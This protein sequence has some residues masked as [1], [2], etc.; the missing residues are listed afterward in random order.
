MNAVRFDETGAETGRVD[1][2][3]ALF[4]AEPNMDVLH[5][6][7]VTYLANQRQG[8][9]AAKTRADVS[10]TNRKPFKQKKTGQARRGDM[11]TN[12]QRGG[13]VYGGP[14]PRDYRQKM[15]KKIKQLALR[16]AL[17][18]RA[19]EEAVS[20]VVDLS[21][22]SG[23]TRD[24][25]SLLK[26]AGMQDKRVLFVADKP[27]ATLQRASRNIEKL[28]LTSVGSL[29]TYA[30]MW[31]ERV[32]FTESALARLSEVSLGVAR[33]NEAGGAQ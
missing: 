28:W 7:V 18:I 31:A 24:V 11:K 14:I 33:S 21:L 27:S 16:S 32:V 23:K 6:A 4:G 29:S 25:N 20:A 13:G 26:S 19:R 10:G 9:A 2:A 3:P 30:V 12:V 5:Q 22:E 15:P 17:S 1:L 8:T